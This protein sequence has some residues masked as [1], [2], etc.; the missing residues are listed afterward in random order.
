MISPTEK[1][2]TPLD[3]REK[4]F[5]RWVIVDNIAE[6][7]REFKINKST[8]YRIRQRE[9]WG[10]RKSQL[11]VEAKKKNNINIIDTELSNLEVVRTIRHEVFV[12]LMTRM[13]LKS[14]HTNVR[15]FVL[16]MELEEKMSGNIP[17]DP[18]E[19][20]INIFNKMPEPD[21]DRLALDTAKV[22]DAI[23]ARDRG[24]IA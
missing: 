8:V 14:F 15:D 10:A 23:R 6:I 19:H 11:I 4:M 5:A 17:T 1:L 16:I 12:K 24:R 20:V 9:G 7:A 13:E 21:Q 22:R 2:T 3:V 18:K